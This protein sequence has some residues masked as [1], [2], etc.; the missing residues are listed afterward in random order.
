[1]YFDPSRGYAI[2][3]HE[4]YGVLTTVD[5]LSEPA[6]GVFYPRKATCEVRSNTGAPEHKTLYEASAVVA[7]D[8]NFS[9]DI[10]TIN[11]PI[12]TRVE[13]RI[14]GSQFTVG[15]TDGPEE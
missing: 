14:N 1:L 15:Q 11:W 6:P 13:D 7:N 3:F 8:P 5:E 2:L 12:S 9:D 4:E 10:F